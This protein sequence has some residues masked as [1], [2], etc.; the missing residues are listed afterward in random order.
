MSPG[1]QREITIAAAILL[2]SAGE[3]LV[4][5]KKNTAS[6][7]QPGGKIDAG[8]TPVQALCRELREE[9]AID[10]GPEDVTFRGIFRETA[11]NEPDTTVVAHVF[12]ATLETAVRPLAEIAE[13]VWLPLSGGGP[14]I[15][16]ARLTEFEILPVARRI[17]GKLEG[18]AA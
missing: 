7:M 14:D 4:V 18:K 12:S 1:T 13:L 9:I 8:E 3:M 5:R 17:A 11:A 16:L 2:N 6:F 10:I 15:A